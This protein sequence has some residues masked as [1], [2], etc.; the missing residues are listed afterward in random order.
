MRIL[1]VVLNI[2]VNFPYIYVCLCT[3]IQVWYAVLV[4][5]ITLLVD[6]TLSYQ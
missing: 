4:D 6:D 1:A 5:K 3:Y 2:Y